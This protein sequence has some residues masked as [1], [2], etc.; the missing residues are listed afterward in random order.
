MK[1]IPQ[2]MKALRDFCFWRRAHL[3][4]L[5]SRP[6]GYVLAECPAVA[7]NSRSMQIRR[8]IPLI[9]QAGDPGAG[10]SPVKHLRPGMRPVILLPAAKPLRMP[11]WIRVC[12][13]NSSSCMRRAHLPARAGALQ[14]GLIQAPERD[15]AERF[16]CADMAG[17]PLKLSPFP[18]GTPCMTGLSSLSPWPVRFH[19]HR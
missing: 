16:S 14:K 11:G 9:E 1:E 15:S 19:T 17:A 3:T 10:V 13:G 5:K 4:S 8:P 7:V 18:H 6:V 12:M 2:G